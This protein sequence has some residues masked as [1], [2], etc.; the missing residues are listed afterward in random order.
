MT[1]LQPRTRGFR[2]PRIAM[3]FMLL[4]FAGVVIAIEMGRAIAMGGRAY[5]FSAAAVLRPL[6]MIFAVPFVAAA[7]AYAIRFIQ[8]AME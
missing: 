7:V 1:R 4:G 3:A 2:F 8:Q 6:F 5:D